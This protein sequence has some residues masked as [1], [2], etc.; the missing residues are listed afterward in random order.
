MAMTLGFKK[1]Y[2]KKKKNSLLMNHWHEC[3]NIFLGTFLG[4]GDSSLFIGSS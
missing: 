3:I 1:V 2:I 4:S